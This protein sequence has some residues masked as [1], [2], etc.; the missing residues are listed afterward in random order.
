MGIFA[1]KASLYTIGSVLC[2]V[3]IF[4]CS[5]YSNEEKRSAKNTG[6]PV[7][8]YHRIV[9]LTDIG[10]K[11]EG[12]TAEQWDEVNELS[13][14]ANVKTRRRAVFIVGGI[15]AKRT[16][17][18]DKVL[19]FLELKATDEDA[20]VREAVSVLQELFRGKNDGT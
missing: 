8:D 4:G 18:L 17:Q 6:I 12:F 9:E 1:R 7:E 15:S 5:K 16:Q 14:N 11:A 10:D 19:E 2:L 3:A 20:E 13:N